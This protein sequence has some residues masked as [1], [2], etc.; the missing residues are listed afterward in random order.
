MTLDITVPLQSGKLSVIAQN[1]FGYSEPVEFE[2]NYIGQTKELFKPNLYILAI[3]VS[4]YDDKDLTLEFASKDAID[5]ANVMKKQKGKLYG[6]VVIKTLTN[7][8][9]SKGEILDALEWLQKQTTSKDVAMLFVAGHGINDD[10]NNFYFLPSNFD[11]NKLKRTG[12]A[13]SDFKSTLSDIS[14]KVLFFADACHSGNV[15]G[16][17]RAIDTN[18]IIA[19]L[20]DAENGI[21]VF[22]SSTGKQYS[23][24]DKKWN[25]GAFTKALVE[26]LEGKA[27]LLGSGKITVDSLSFYVSE[28]VKELTGGRQTPAGNKP[29][30]ISDFP[31]GVK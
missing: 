13:Y 21:I 16:K 20:N 1:E 5:F 23:L 22:T 17:R 19:E 31:I 27:D 24:E 10:N 28:R 26:G 4:S 15:M 18:G 14:G 3:G 8:E 11:D 7:K 29:N 12:V 9:A 2:I 6:D 30:T 25:N